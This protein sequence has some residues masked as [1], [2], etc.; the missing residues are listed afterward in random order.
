MLMLPRWGIFWIAVIIAAVVATR[1]DR[2]ARLAIAVI[3]S[4]LAVYI[5]VYVVTA[6][7]VSDLIAVTADRLLMH[8][9]GPALFLLASGVAQ[10]SSLRPAD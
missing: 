4:M 3:G 6:W 9:I 8:V 2:R 10:A 5:G 1:L 7:N